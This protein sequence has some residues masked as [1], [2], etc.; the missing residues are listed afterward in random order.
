MISFWIYTHAYLIWITG[1]FEQ[2]NMDVFL[3]TEYFV[4]SV[5]IIIIAS[6]KIQIV[7][8]L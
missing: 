8:L 4:L 3:F 5:I 2:N 1:E 7:N 6:S